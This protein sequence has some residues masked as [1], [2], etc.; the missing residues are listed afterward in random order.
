MG[1]GKGGGGRRRRRRREKRGGHQHSMHAAAGTLHYTPTYL[2]TYIHTLTGVTRFLRVWGRVRQ[3]M[4]RAGW[5]GQC[6]GGGRL[7]VAAS[8]GAGGSCVR[9]VAAVGVAAYGVYGVQREEQKVGRWQLSALPCVEGR[10]GQ[11]RAGRLARLM[12]LSGCLAVCLSCPSV[13]SIY[14]PACLLRI[15]CPFVEGAS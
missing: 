1:G 4:L 9:R 2:G 6:G 14:L 8:G 7:R 13:H 5:P 3:R 11:G 15:V 12:C 10:A